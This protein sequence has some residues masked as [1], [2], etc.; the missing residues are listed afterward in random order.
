VSL[1][2]KRKL[3]VSSYADICEAAPY[4][5]APPA[6]TQQPL[7]SLA[8][9]FCSS[10][11][12][13]EDEYDFLRIFDIVFVIDDSGSMY[14]SSWRETREALAAITSICT[15]RDSD[16]IDI[17]FLNHQDKPEFKNITSRNMVNKIFKAVRPEGSTPTGERLDHILQQYLHDLERDPTMKPVNII[18][19]TDGE[20]SDDVESPIIA[21]AKKLDK[22]NAPA[23]QVGIQFFQVGKSHHA[24]KHLKQLD[25]E[26]RKISGDPEL[27]DIVDTVAFTD[28]G[29]AKLTDEGIL[30]VRFGR[31][32]VNR[33][34]RL[35]QDRLYLVPS[36]EDGTAGQKGCIYNSRCFSRLAYR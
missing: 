13:G 21:T 35:T 16:G 33:I 17:Y 24:D 4:H 31:R 15:E 12:A 10:S 32:G 36:I 20:L 18:V 34:Q 14:G 19:I 27:R 25:D 2:K 3:R 5:D 9:K 26:I 1:E 11:A 30:K 8:A 6:Y 22:L 23:W 28:A 29:G 7:P